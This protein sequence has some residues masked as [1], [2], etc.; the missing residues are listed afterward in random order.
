MQSLWFIR[1]SLDSASGRTDTG[2][3]MMMMNEPRNAYKP[4]HQPS[5][6]E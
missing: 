4:F 1:K 2:N 5:D 3:Q 6:D